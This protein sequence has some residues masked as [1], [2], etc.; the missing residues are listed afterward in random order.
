[1]CVYLLFMRLLRMIYVRLYLSTGDTLKEAEAE[2]TPLYMC[3]VK[4]VCRV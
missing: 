1:M 2:T 3:L 4:S